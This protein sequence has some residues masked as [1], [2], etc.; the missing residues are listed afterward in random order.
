METKYCIYNGDTNQDGI[1]DGFDLS[2]IDNNILNFA[3]GYLSTDING[4]GFIDAT[5]A[6]IAGNNAYNFIGKITP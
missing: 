3:N 2:M 6:Q 4:D 1:I 5:D